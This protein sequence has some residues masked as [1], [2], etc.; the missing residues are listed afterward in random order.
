MGRWIVSVKEMQCTSH[1]RRLGLSRIG[2]T[3]GFLQALK[4]FVKL[5]PNIPVAFK[6][7]TASQT[8]GG[9]L[10]H[11]YFGLTKKS[12]APRV[13]NRHYAACAVYREAQILLDQ[14][15]RRYRKPGRAH[16]L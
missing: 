15:S 3:R 16:H 9:G 12:T 11:N 4:I 1:C 13:A 2:Q 8:E 7:G 5:A 6:P 14:D 10:C